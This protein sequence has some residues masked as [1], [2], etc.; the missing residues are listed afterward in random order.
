MK[1]I[2]ITVTAAIIDKYAKGDRV[3]VNVNTTKDPEYWP[4]TI[5]RKSVKNNT[6]WVEYDDG[7]YDIF[8]ATNSKVGVLGHA[9]KKSKRNRAIPK[10]VIHEYLD[11]AIA[12]KGVGEFGK[13]TI[14]T[15][16]RI[17]PKS[18]KVDTVSVSPKAQQEIPDN[19]NKAAKKSPLK[20][21]VTPT[22]T[23]KAKEGVK[24]MPTKPNP[25]KIAE[26]EKQYTSYYKLGLEI[27]MMEKYVPNSSADVAKL[28]RRY[29]AIGK[30]LVQL[31][32]QTGDPA[33][34]NRIRKT[35]IV[36]KSKDIVPKLEEKFA[37][38]IA[39]YTPKWSM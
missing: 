38:Y 6:V 23:K 13:G 12:P 34:C 20:P 8:K 4:A 39:N 7:S 17:V 14:K 3:I 18:K 28:R 16:K 35:V 24:P 9:I 2:N 36:Y 15:K 25:N 11:G 1:K 21:N 29:D 31:E 32:M 27:H 37:E 19:V 26:Y 30:E 33:Q 22:K 10:E 5:T